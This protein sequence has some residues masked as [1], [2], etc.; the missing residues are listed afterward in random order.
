M[1]QAR[2]GLV[3]ATKPWVVGAA[4]TVP[5]AVFYVACGVAVLLF[6][7]GTLTFFNT[8]FHGIDLT[9]IKR[10]P[11]NA[12]TFNDWGTGFVTAIVSGFLAGST[13]GWARNFFARFA[14]TSEK[15]RGHKS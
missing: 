10:D 9:A 7:D 2:G 6:P 4:F 5:V 1:Q 3:I 15:I 13:Y 11:T 8:W 12:L 14:D